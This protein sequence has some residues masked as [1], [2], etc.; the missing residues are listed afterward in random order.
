MGSGAMAAAC[1][2]RPKECLQSFERRGLR[3]GV[4]VEGYTGIGLAWLL[5]GGMSFHPSPIN[6][7][8]CMGQ[9]TKTTCLWVGGM[10]VVD[11]VRI[12]RSAEGGY[13]WAVSREIVT[14]I[15]ENLSHPSSRPIHPSPRAVS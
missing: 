12:V 4:E 6:R 8:S 7:A 11:V 14:R 3:D 2:M 15:E 1:L 10:S 13:R 5:F 9:M